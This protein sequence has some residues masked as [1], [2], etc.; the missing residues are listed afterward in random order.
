MQRLSASW[1]ADCKNGSTEYGIV[2]A[3]TPASK[4]VCNPEADRPLLAVRRIA[5]DL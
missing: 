1:V 3:C 4:E 2:Y 5:K